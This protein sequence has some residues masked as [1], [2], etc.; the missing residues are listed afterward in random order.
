MQ[1]AVYHLAPGGALVTYGPYLEGS[2]STSVGNLAFDGSLRERNALWGI[3][4]V[5]EVAQQAGRVGLQ[6]A[7]RHAMP[8]NNL[9]LVWARRLH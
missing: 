9:L 4:Q 5:G 3:R 1:G 2:V 8:A 6:L 7:A